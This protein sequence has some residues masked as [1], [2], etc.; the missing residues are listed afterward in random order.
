M[1]DFLNLTFKILAFAD[2]QVTNDPRLKHADWLRNMAGISV[3][4]AK[5][6]GFR[7][8]PG[9][10]LSVFNSSRTTTID[11]TTSFNL[12]LLPVEGASRY[13]FSYISGTLP[14]LRT[15]RTL[16][17][18]GAVL[19]LTANANSTLSVHAA[20]PLFA[21]VVAGD[22]VFIPHLSTGDA[23]NVLSILNAGYWVVL[24]VAGTQDITLV[25]PVGQL[26]EGTTETQTLVS[27]DQFR[28][29]SATGVQVGDSVDVSAGF[30]PAVLTSFDVVAVTDVFFEVISSSPLPSQ[31]GI[32]P[33]ATG[34]LFYD[35]MKR[36]VYVESSQEVVVR[37]N[38]DTGNFQRVQPIDPS[39][40][41]KPGP[42][43]KWG[44]TWSLSVF[45]RSAVTAEVTVIYCE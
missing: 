35:G 25:R 24:S 1:N 34:I 39:D 43:M 33:T 5:S 15:G 29:F 38:G 23:A 13:R 44:P 20:A 42:Y 22:S 36:F 31:T 21:G 7:V 2:Q 10:V 6:Q 9:D 11:N 4:D 41:N 18:A 30:A 32:L 17:S 28:A 37:V 14:G 45:N 19:T 8:A 3:T 26:F 27:N 16:L 12:T 40:A